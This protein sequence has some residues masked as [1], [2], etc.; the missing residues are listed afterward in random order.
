[1]KMQSNMLN[2]A[3]LLLLLLPGTAR[4]ELQQVGKGQAYYMKFIKVYEATLFSEQPVRTDEILSRDVSKCLHLAYS[5]DI[6][7]E[8]LVKAA[9]TVLARQFPESVLTPLKDEIELLHGGYRD[10]SKGDTFTLCYDSG[11][12][13]TILE[14]NGDAVARVRSADFARVYFSIW[15]GADRPLDRNLRD[16]LLAGLLKG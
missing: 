13:E 2:V 4:A 15:L 12:S 14:Y 6:R 5:V 16:D 1:M 3:V 9:G 11:N 7:Q 10:V 8:D